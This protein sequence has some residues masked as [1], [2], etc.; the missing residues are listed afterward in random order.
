MGVHEIAASGFGGAAEIYDK[1]R[2][3]YPLAVV[4]YFVDNLDIGPGHRVLDLAAGTGI[5]TGLI[6]NSGATLIACEPVAGMREVLRNKY[7]EIP[8][9]A[10]VAENLPF[11]DGSLHAVTIL[12]ALHWFDGQRATLELHRVLR[13]RGRVGFGWNARDRSIEWVD[14]VWAIMDRV[15]KKAPWRNHREDQTGTTAVSQ[16]G[17][18]HG[19]TAGRAGVFVQGFSE[20]RY[21]RFFHEQQTTPQ[22][23]IDRVASVSHVQ[24]LPEPERQRVLDEVRDIVTNHPQTAGQ[25]VLNLGYWTDCY[26]TERL[27]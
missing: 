12:Q 6:A 13:S 21:T 9:A 8:T 16:F 17:D 11:A 22:G 19:W 1:A 23:V 15:E 2:P 18:P 7:P 20:V 27:E 14:L 3:S 25:N 5:F 10:G 26:W 24:I 4:K